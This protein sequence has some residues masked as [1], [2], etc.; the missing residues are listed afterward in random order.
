MALERKRSEAGTY[1]LIDNK[2]LHRVKLLVDC[3][4]LL[5]D[6]KM[7]KLD[8]QVTAPATLGPRRLTQAGVPDITERGCSTRDGA[9]AADAAASMGDAWVTLCV[10]CDQSSGSSL[11]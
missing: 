11:P 3:H 6:G 4:H 10:E 1:P 7:S 2:I 9:A 8:D 5:R